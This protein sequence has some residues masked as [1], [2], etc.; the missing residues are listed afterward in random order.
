MY[1]LLIAG[2]GVNP[3]VSD[4]DYSQCIVQCWE[5]WMTII[6]ISQEQGK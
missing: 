3:S 4:V 1:V 6:I 2:L 5:Y